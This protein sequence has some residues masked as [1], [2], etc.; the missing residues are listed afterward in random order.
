MPSSRVSSAAPV[1]TSPAAREAGGPASDP[2]A[3]TSTA[4]RPVTQRSRSKSWISVSRNR[5]PDAAR[6]AAGGGSRSPVTARTVCSLP[7]R[8]DRTASR[9]PA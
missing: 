6:Y 8:P 3:Y 5:P 4:S 7:S 2:V 1:S 9:A